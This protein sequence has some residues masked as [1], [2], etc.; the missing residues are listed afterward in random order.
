MAQ[1]WVVQ[2][3][4]SPTFKQGAF[5][6]L[7]P[8][9]IAAIA[10]GDLVT[11]SLLHKRRHCGHIQE[12]LVMRVR[13]IDAGRFSGVL[14]NTSQYGEGLEAGLP[15][16]CHSGKIVRTERAPV[17]PSGK[18]IVQHPTNRVA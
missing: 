17:E 3:A 4:I 13:S 12:D 2:G 11:M 10:P 1:A 18:S 7:S 6:A 8:E 5:P 9:V 16:T 15:V 14:I